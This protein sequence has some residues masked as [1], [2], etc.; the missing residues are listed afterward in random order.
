MND[1]SWAATVR[2]VHERSN[3]ICEYCQTSQRVTGQALH[4]EHI[5]PKGGNLLKNLGSAC[6]SCNLSKARAISAPDPLTGQI[7]SLF[8]PRTQN[9]ADHFE[10]TP[11]G[12][13]I[14]GRTAV[15]RATIV[16]LK[17]NAPRIVE[18]RAIWVRA[19]VHPPKITQ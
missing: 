9:W 17:M 4:V 5:D 19:G 3:Y 18:A 6:A 13:R 8:N 14:V 11:S 15:G 10:W 7:V 1:L 16:R 12:D 2:F